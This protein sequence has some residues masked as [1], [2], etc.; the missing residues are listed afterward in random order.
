V[1]S[2][3]QL[4]ISPLELA[5][6]DIESDFKREHGERCPTDDRS[7]RQDQERRHLNS[8]QWRRCAADE[9]EMGL[10]KG[11]CGQAFVTSLLRSLTL[12]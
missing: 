5:L 4:D 7:S 8:P 11:Y 10:T 12:Q 3:S 2:R 6:D 9:Y 1:P